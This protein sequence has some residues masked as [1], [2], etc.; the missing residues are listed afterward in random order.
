M[1]HKFN[2]DNEDNF[3]IQNNGNEKFLLINRKICTQHSHCFASEG[4]ECIIMM[5]R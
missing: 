4:V 5:T 3:R 2:I 1:L